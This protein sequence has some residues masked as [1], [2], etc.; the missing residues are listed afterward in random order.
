MIDK[1][2]QTDKLMGQ[3]DLDTQLNQSENEDFEDLKKYK[4]KILVRVWSSKVWA[5]FSFNFD[6]NFDYFFHN[7]SNFDNELHFF[8]LGW[9]Q[10]RSERQP[11]LELAEFLPTPT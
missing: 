8:Q 5:N 1:L 11:K 2:R 3:I 10:N 4:K 7:N 6:S 9:N